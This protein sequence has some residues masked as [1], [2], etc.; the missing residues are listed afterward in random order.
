[1]VSSK[2]Q[3]V[4]KLS[5]ETATLYISRNYVG[6]C[7]LKIILFRIPATVAI[8]SAVIKTQ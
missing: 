8:I 4:L 7:N 5:D 1:M 6:I 2:E 3:I